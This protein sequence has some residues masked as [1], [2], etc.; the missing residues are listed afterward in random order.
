MKFNQADP[1]SKVD[2]LTSVLYLLR[3]QKMSLKGR[4]SEC[5]IC[6]V[7]AEQLVKIHVVIK[8]G[9]PIC[10]TLHM[11]QVSCLVYGA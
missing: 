11:W 4:S 3:Q 2:G 1:Q 6:W 8:Y 9:K 5:A 7:V 10:D